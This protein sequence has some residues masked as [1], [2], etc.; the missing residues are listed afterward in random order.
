MRIYSQENEIKFGDYDFDLNRKSSCEN[1]GFIERIV[2]FVGKIF[3]SFFKLFS[4]FVI[5]F[6]LF[7]CRAF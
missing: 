5:V 4:S 1:R 6:S 3:I 7:T 2:S